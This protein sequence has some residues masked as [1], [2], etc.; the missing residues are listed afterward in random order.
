ME[1][2]LRPHEV[3]LRPDA[4]RGGA[5][6]AVVERVEYHGAFLLHTVQLPSGARVRSWQPHAVR[7]PVGAEVGVGVVPGLTPTLLLD[8]RAVT[9]PP[10]R[11]GVGN[12]GRR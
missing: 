1:V 4:T 3:A 2:V 11:D 6:A 12:N 7:H 8:G 10:S 9:G 5:P